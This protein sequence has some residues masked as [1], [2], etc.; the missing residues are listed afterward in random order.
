MSEEKKQEYT[1]EEVS[2]HNTE[3]DCWLVIGNMT[4]GGPKVYDITKYLDDHPGGAEVMLDVA[5]QDADE[6]FEDIG[7][8]NDARDE[9]KKHYIGEFKMSEEEMAKAKAEAEAKAAAKNAAGGLTP[10]VLVVVLVA[11]GVGYYKTQME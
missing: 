4:N 7:H 3:S 2:K 8:S 9:L 11:I 1:L 10:I 6:F 5:G